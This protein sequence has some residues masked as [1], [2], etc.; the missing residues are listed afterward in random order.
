MYF[1]RLFFAALLALGCAPAVALPPVEVTGLDGQALDLSSFAGRSVLVV[2]TASLCG[3]TPQYEELQ[4][5]QERYPPDEFTVLAVPSNSFR[6]ELSSGE[7][8]EA[9]CE[10]H[11][12]ITFP[13]T[14]IAP[15]IGRNA[16][17]IYRWLAEHGVRPRWNFHKALVSPDGQV[18]A[19]WP[20][21]ISPAHPSVIAA[22]EE[23]L[24]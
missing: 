1:K 14:E 24:R 16:H 6:Q 11:F 5:L 2:N 19:D 12:G 10:V 13:M 20:S 8:V 4:A 17:P 18:I 7:E 15:V 22:I 9:F 23:H 21:Q 3:F